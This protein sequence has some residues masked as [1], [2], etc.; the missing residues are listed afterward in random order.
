[1][2]NDVAKEF[3]QYKKKAIHE[4]IEKI[5]T[6]WDRGQLSKVEFSKMRGV[7]D[8]QLAIFKELTKSIGYN[9]K[10]L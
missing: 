1:M 10:D 8:I 6:L 5:K 4:R 7:I 3:L 9:W 2:K